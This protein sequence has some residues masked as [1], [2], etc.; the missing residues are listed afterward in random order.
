MTSSFA[1][2]A[3]IVSFLLPPT[4]CA[5]ESSP[6]SSSQSAPGRALMPNDPG[7][8]LGAAARVNG[9]G[10]A[11]LGGAGLAPWHI[12]ASYQTFDTKGHS[13]S[14]GTYEEFWVSDTKN[15]YSYLSS[16]FNQTDFATQSGLYR[17]GNQNWPGF[18]E[19]MVRTQ[20]IDPIPVAI[21]LVGLDVGKNRRSFGKV[22]LECVTLMSSRIFPIN[23]GYCFEQD[24]PMLR[25]VA[26]SGGWN[27]VS[28]NDVV[29]FQGRFIARD[30]R[31]SDKGH[32]HLALRVDEI[33][34]LSTVNESDFA[35][36]AD[37]ASV[38]IAKITIP[39]ETMKGRLL[40]QT[41]P[42]YPESAKAYH[43]EGTII[44]D[45]TIGK[46][47]H[48]ANAQAVSGP[49]SLRKAASDSVREWEFRPF[50]VLGE[51]REVE[52]SVRVVFELR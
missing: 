21:N 14:S 13:Q 30:I 46:D 52:S 20:L 36:P 1:V 44:L 6:T 9:L 42:H 43:I 41:L 51:P 17:T 37:A 10:G 24:Q 38:L 40:R 35:P 34:T 50:L 11:G 22:K 27:D 31:V 8:I 3:L 16:T 33:E 5:Q 26:S 7:A 12:R 28:Y 15:K 49:D 23:E 4:V 2:A 29:I 48:V 25:F 18:L 47:G 32:L 39:E 19:T 45:I